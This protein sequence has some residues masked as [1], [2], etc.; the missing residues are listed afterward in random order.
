M[1]RRQFNQ[2][3]VAIGATIALPTLADPTDTVVSM[4][5]ELEQKNQLVR[6]GLIC[7]GGADGNTV[8]SIVRGLPDI[9]RT[10]AIDTDVVALNSAG[11]DRL[12]LIGSG[13]EKP[14][15]PHQAFEMAKK[16]ANQIEAAMNDFDL[17]FVVAGMYGAAGKGIAPVIANIAR[18]KRIIILGIAIMP[19]E[20]LDVHSTP[21]ARY[22]IHEFQ[23]AGATVFPINSPCMATKYG[24]DYS[25]ISQTIKTLFFSVSRSLNQSRG[26]GI[27]LEELNLALTPGGVAS[28]GF[29]SAKGA[30]RAERAIQLA[31][32][33]P[34]L[35]ANKLRT[36][37]G[38]L[39]NI[40]GNPA[41]FM[42]SEF[43]MVARFVG[44]YLLC[45]PWHLYSTS[46]DESVGDELFVSILATAAGS[47]NRPTI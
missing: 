13:V 39:V 36:A 12:V 3:T 40:R 41:N 21:R 47:E 7:V 23:R 30:N 45:D 8:A 19:T 35:G 6:I 18:M 46:A 32:T 14:Q 27:D 4:D 1:N 26:I 22:G 11:A 20:W 29:G 2:A 9:T 28:I 44:S 16:Q 34:L 5:L 43:K 33:H 25:N 10:I 31:I 38:V 24:G 37:T 15:H 17:V 42:F